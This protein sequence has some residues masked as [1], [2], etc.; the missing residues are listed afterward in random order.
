MRRAFVL[1]AAMS[2]CCGGNP[3]APPPPPPPFVG[4]WS[5]LLDISYVFPLTGETT[6][7][8]CDHQWTVQSQAGTAF[9]G[10]FSSG[11]GSAHFPRQEACIDSGTFSGFVSADGQVTGLTFTPVLLGGIS[12]NRDCSAVARATLAGTTNGQ[13]ISAQ[14]ADVIECLVSGSPARIN[15]SVVLLLNKRNP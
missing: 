10:A 15:R 4:D 11:G 8:L 13:S 3:V 5:G 6:H 14:G 1:L 12:V 9:S 2:I 7:D